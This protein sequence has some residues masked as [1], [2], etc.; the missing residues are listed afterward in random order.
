MPALLYLAGDTPT[1]VASGTTLMGVDI[2][3]LTHD[4]WRAL[5]IPED[6]IRVIPDP[7]NT[8]QEIDAYAQLM[9]EEG[10]HR[11]G[12]VTSATHM[13]RAQAL[14]R[15]RGIAMTPLP[16]DFL[17][18]QDLELEAFLWPVPQARALTNLEIV[19]WEVLG[20]LAMRLMGF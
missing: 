1:L 3:A 4:H 9:E 10:W 13:R 16:A 2:S 5:G 15:L 14:C 20:L 12:L 8:A 11:V 7:K 6:A 19:V 17:G 18:P